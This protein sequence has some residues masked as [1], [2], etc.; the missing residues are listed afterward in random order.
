MRSRGDNHADARC[1]PD[2]ACAGVYALCCH[3][4]NIFLLIPLDEQRGIV[5][6]SDYGYSWTPIA[7]MKEAAN[8]STSS[9]NFHERKGIRRQVPERS[10][11]MSSCGDPIHCERAAEVKV[12]IAVGPGTSLQA[13]EFAEVRKEG[14]NC[15]NGRMKHEKEQGSESVNEEPR[16]HTCRTRRPTKCCGVEVTVVSRTT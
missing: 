2:W 4:N 5:A 8:K 10:R 12:S 16:S 15:S 3:R 9:A 7:W 14:T 1:G 11:G 6:G 13:L